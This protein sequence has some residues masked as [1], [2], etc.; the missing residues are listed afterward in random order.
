MV[1][2]LRIAARLTH[3]SLRSN[4]AEVWIPA[5]AGKTDGVIPAQ[6][7][8]QQSPTAFVQI[9]KEQSPFEFFRHFGKLSAGKL[10]TSCRVQRGANLAFLQSDFHNYFWPRAN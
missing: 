1:E 7:G 2:V 9:F 3:A 6:A 4:A 8:I 5:C 10:R